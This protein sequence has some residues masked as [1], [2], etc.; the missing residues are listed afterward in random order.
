MGIIGMGSGEQRRGGREERRGLG[1]RGGGMGGE[2]KTA[3]WRKE[4]MD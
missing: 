1:N 2:E 4:E 3:M